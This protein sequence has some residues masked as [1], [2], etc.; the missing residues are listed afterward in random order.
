MVNLNTKEISG[1]DFF[2]SLGACLEASAGSTLVLTAN[3]RQKRFLNTRL[4]RKLKN[5]SKACFPIESFATWSTNAY[6]DLQDL[7][8]TGFNRKMTQPAEESLLWHE[9]AKVAAEEWRDD[10]NLLVS[11]NQLADL[12]SATANTIEQFEVPLSKLDQFPSSETNTFKTVYAKFQSILENEQLE[13]QNAKYIRLAAHFSGTADDSQHKAYKHVYLYGFAELPPLLERLAHAIGQ[14]ICR[15]VVN[16]AA[17]ST[18]VST[19]NSTATGPTGFTPDLFAEED[20]S[21][22]PSGSVGRGINTES[23]KPIR[24]LECASQLDEMQWAAHWSK[25]CLEQNPNASIGIVVP[26]LTRVKSR[27][28]TIFFKTLEPQAYLAAE[29]QLIPTTFD[30]TAAQALDTTP[31]V[32][33]ALEL[34]EFTNN[35]IHTERATA[36]LGSEYWGAGASSERL[37][38]AAALKTQVATSV[39]TATVVSDLMYIESLVNEQSQESSQ[40]GDNNATPETGVTSDQ[41]LDSE[42]LITLQKQRPTLGGK[43]TLHLWLHWYTEFLNIMG[44]PGTRALGSYDYQNV[45]AFFDALDKLRAVSLPG[46]EVLSMRDFQQLLTRW[47]SKQ[48]FHPEVVNPKIHVLGLMEAAGLSF[49]NIHIIGLTEDVLPQPPAPDPLLPIALQ[50]EFNTPKSSAEREHIYSCALLE[51]VFAASENVSCSYASADD[52]GTVKLSP[53]VTALGMSISHISAELTHGDKAKGK[54]NAQLDNIVDQHVRT[55]SAFTG[56]ELINIG[57]APQIPKNTRIPG[58]AGHLNLHRTNPLYAFFRY[59]LNA[60][61][62]YQKGYGFDGGTRGSFFHACVAKVYREYHNISAL[63]ELYQQQGR[64]DV[65]LSIIETT[66]T[67]EQNRREAVPPMIEQYEK[68]RALQHLVD[69]LKVDTDRTVNWIITDIEENTEVRIHERNITVQIDRVDTIDDQQFVFD[70]KTRATKITPLLSFALG[71]YQLPLYSLTKDAPILGGVGYI[72][73]EEHSVSYAGLADIDSG[74]GGISAPAKIK[75]AEA[76]TE[77]PSLLEHWRVDVHERVQRIVNGEAMYDVGDVEKNNYQTDLS[78]AVRQEEKEA[79]R[80]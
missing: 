44:W 1:T 67:S 35:K 76:P 45:Q 58:G 6:L 30:I 55:A 22:A 14:K 72:N 18:D 13:S 59:R 46:T 28:E 17:N 63:N 77:W 53:L 3:S 29:S 66:F 41:L 43:R 25:Q 71:D 23:S 33:T 8:V 62:S 20:L 12:C 68:N 7:A 39:R 34:L 36:L 64:D 42:R 79:Q 61:K 70:Y 19:N 78:C 21:I 69:L 24:V 32:N 54:N 15:V 40:T 27:I 26:D 11:E 4:H 65:L 80:V 9:A 49:D 73:I 51:S 48:V 31:C 75:S 38:T 37:A 50:R 56:F 47:V 2:K 10:T 57:A 60:D 5:T 52:T 74:I 16:L